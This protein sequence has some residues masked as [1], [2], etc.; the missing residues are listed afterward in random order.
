MASA[1]PRI[2]L[3]ADMD[4]FYAAVEQRD[5]PK[6][7]GR[8]ILVGGHSNRGVVLTASYEAR[9]F[10]VASAMPMA[11]ARRRCPQA[12][13]VPPR[14][15]RYQD[16][17]ATIMRIFADF[18]PD[19]EALSLD[20]A[21]LEMTGASHIFG[22]PSQMAAKL[23]AR[24]RE[25]TGLAVSV[26]VSGTK[27][28]AKVASDFGKPDGLVVVPQPD[29]QAWLAPLPVGRL[30][31]AGPKTQARLSELG[32]RTI[33][34]IAATDPDVLERELGSIGRRFHQLAHAE[35]VRVVARIRTSKSIGCDATLEKDVH[36]RADLVLHVR[37]S[38]DTIGRR[39]RRKGFLAGGVRVKLKTHD[40]RVFT[41]QRK[42]ADP[43][44][45]ADTLHKIGTLLLDEFDDPGPFRLVGLAAYDLVQEPAQFDLFGDDARQ[46]RLELAIDRATE[47]FGRDALTRATRLIDGPDREGPNLDYLDDEDE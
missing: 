33:G 6:L 8:P 43:T 21:F 4:A 30:W 44:D 15:E 11:L 34:Q 17:S 28:V 31:G 5:D 32:Y 7:R 29:A 42:L 19:V 27:Y 47:R 22:E 41:R 26:G 24:V 36:R 18:S 20:E 35:D 1:W 3:H 25:E 39:L 16:V 38:A 45:V 37:R 40:F 13:I 9:P 14:F 23:K 2:V 10:G 12:L 46:R